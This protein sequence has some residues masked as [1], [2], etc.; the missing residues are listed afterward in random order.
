[1][2]VPLPELKL[3]ARRS[4]S[5]DTRGL[6]Y[7]SALAINGSVFPELSNQHTRRRAEKLQPGRIK[8]NAVQPALANVH[9]VARRSIG[10][11]VS[12]EVA[13]GYQSLSLAGLE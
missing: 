13:A 1:M 11:E 6:K 4:P 2:S 12:A 5:G 10:G 8:R 7:R 3:T 9:Q